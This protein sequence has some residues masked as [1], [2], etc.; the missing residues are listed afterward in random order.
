MFTLEDGWFLE[1]RGKA[2]RRGV[3][4]RSCFTTHRDLGGFFLEDPYRQRAT[5]RLFERLIRIAA[6]VGAGAAGVPRGAPRYHRAG[7]LLLGHRA[8]LRRRRAPDRA[9]QLEPVRAADPLHG[10]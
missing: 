1:L 10:R 9:R 7:V 5:R 6:L 8:R 2:E 4:I 3:R